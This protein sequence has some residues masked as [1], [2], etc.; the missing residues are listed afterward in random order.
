MNIGVEASRPPSG[1]PA[2]GK[3]ASGFLAQESGSEEWWSGPGFAASKWRTPE[4]G[5]PAFDDSSELHPQMTHASGAY[6]VAAT[7]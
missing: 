2:P 6:E 1:E 5:L 4:S 7:K 3:V